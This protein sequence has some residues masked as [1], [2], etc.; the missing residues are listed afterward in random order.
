MEFCWGI[1]DFVFIL[2]GDFLFLFWFFWIDF[3]F[4]FFLVV[5]IWWLF[6]C[7]FEVIFIFLGDF[8]LDFKFLFV[9]CKGIFVW[10]LWVNFDFVFI[11]RCV[12]CVFF[13]WLEDVDL[14]NVERFLGWRIVVK[15]ELVFFVSVGGVWFVNLFISFKEDFG[16]V[17]CG[18]L[19]KARLFS[20]WKVRLFFL[21]LCNR[22]SLLDVL[23]FVLDL[24]LFL[25]EEE[26]GICKLGEIFFYN[27][28][29]FG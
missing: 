25:K 18:S 2:I 13:F 15:V 12:L 21:V 10:F 11:L 4:V 28:F 1:C 3:E 19:E 5:V 6:W 17:V 14:E 9:L 8:L 24:C 16:W 22:G 23:I 20:F 26:N 27:F 29:W 7:D